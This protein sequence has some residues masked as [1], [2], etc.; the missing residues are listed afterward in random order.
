MHK[1]KLTDIEIIDRYNQDIPISE[2]SEAANISRP[3]IYNTLKRN[4]IDVNRRTLLTLT[5]PFCGET[6]TRPASRNKNPK[7]G[8]CTIQCFHADRST[9]GL[10]SKIGSSLSSNRPDKNPEQFD[11]IRKIHLQRASK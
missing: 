8:Y 6:F 10:Y 2:I 9:V 1:S 11:R 3:A 5:C 4:G 7:S